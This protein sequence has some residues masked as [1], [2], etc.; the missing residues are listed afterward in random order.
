MQEHYEQRCI[1]K[2][3]SAPDIG[4]ATARIVGVFPTIEAV[5]RM[6][7]VA[8]VKAS[9]RVFVVSDQLHGC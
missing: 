8:K 1:I 7:I 2:C 4:L 5:C 6:S 9:W 3:S